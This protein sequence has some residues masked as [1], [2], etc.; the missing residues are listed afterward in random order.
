MIWKRIR[1]NVAGKPF[2]FLLTCSAVTPVNVASTRKVR[3]PVPLS[4]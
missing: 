2:R 1:R 4:R 3:W